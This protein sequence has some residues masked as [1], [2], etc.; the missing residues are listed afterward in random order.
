MKLE[1]GNDLL[2]LRYYLPRVFGFKGIRE[3]GA[4]LCFHHYSSG[5]AM[6]LDT[7]HNTPLELKNSLQKDDGELAD[8]T[9]AGEALNVVLDPKKEKKLLAK[10]DAAF[11]P[12]IMF[13]YLTCF[14]D[15]SNIGEPQVLFVF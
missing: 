14:L 1:I 12:V 6:V 4:I 5:L 11:I 3:T 7:V 2:R 15:R 9:A 13:T 8:E 10:L